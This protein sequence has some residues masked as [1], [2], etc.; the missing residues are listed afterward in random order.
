MDEARLQI[1]SFDPLFAPI[2]ASWVRTEQELFWL[3]PRTPPPL[4]P[5]KVVGWTRQRGQAFLCFADRESTPLGY[6]E[7][8]PLSAE[9]HHLWLGH[10]IVDPQRRGVGLGLR[11]TDAL[12]RRAFHQFD[13]AKLSLVVFPE[14][15]A[16]VTCYR[17]LGFSQ[18]ADEYHRFDGRS[19]RFRMLRFE[20]STPP[21]T[22][23]SEGGTGDNCAPIG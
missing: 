13:A 14:N 20:R 22:L 8:N 16:A 19:G 7:L 9:P 6:G 2:V 1:R 10:V 21:D 23:H 18:V 5:S 15:I 17:R 11:L 12:T 4:S 3:A